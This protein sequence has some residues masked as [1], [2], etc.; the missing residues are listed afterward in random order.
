MG[1]V[2]LHEDTYRMAA[3]LYSDEF[4][5]SLSTFFICINLHIPAE[6]ERSPDKVP[7]RRLQIVVEK[8]RS[9]ALLGFFKLLNLLLWTMLGPLHKFGPYGSLPGKHRLLSDQLT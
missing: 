2:L 7:G 9:I 5:S 8:T 6:I 4:R 3:D 1:D